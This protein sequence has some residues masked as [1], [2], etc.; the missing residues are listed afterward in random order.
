MLG[1]YLPRYLFKHMIQYSN[2][3]FQKYDCKLPGDIFGSPTVY[4]FHLLRHHRSLELKERLEIPGDLYPVGNVKRL[5]AFCTGISLA[6]SRP[7][8]F[9]GNAK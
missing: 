4:F 1:Q 6:I 3:C 2:V 9:K 5:R 8:Q 7:V